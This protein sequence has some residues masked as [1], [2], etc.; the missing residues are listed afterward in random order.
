M[1]EHLHAIHDLLDDFE[2]E[3][4]E[5]NAVWS[6]VR[7]D[8]PDFDQISEERC[9]ERYHRLWLHGATTSFES[10]ELE[11]WLYDYPPVTVA[12]NSLAQD[13]HEAW[14]ETL[15]QQG[16][17]GAY[18][19]DFQEFQILEPSEQETLVQFIE[20]LSQSIEK[21]GKG[22]RLGWRALRSFLDFVRHRYPTEQVAFVE[23]LFPQKMDLRHGR[24]RRLIPS[25][26]YPIPE[27]TAAEILI[28]FAY[29]CRNG[30]PDAR[31]TAAEGMALCWLC[32]ASSRI[33]LPKTL[34]MITG[35]EATAVLPGSEF[36]ISKVP[37]FGS[38]CSTVDDEFSV[39]R[40]PTWFGY[41][42][43]K[44]SNRIAAFLK[45]VAQISSKQPRNTILQRPAASLRRAFDAVLQT[46]A[47]P[48]EYGNITYL[49]L[50]NQPHIFGDHRPQ[51]K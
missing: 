36:S 11:Q 30:R 43:L 17:L 34:E 9:Q 39:L 8:N 49:S 5:L 2:A 41:Q 46:V 33:R 44:I 25:E 50:L 32:V 19:V 37:T 26:A 1:N 40:V 42:P 35:L 23:H 18:Y 15:E 45:I 29:R 10:N 7:K 21:K 27:K 51:P 22:H 12:A 47:P 24:I 4:S 28:E 38:K 13:A 48:S 31:H 3:L 20:R 14:K 6:R 16:P